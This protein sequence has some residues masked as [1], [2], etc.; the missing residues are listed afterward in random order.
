MRVAM[1][2]AGWI[3]ADH[4]ERIA[5]TDGLELVAICDVDEERARALASGADVHRDWREM[6]E[7]AEPEV[8]F[9][10][11]PP[12]LHRD[13]TLVALERGIHVYLEKPVARGLE[14]A[15]AIVDAAASAQAICAVGYQWRGVAALDPL[16]E[17]LAG[18]E[19]GLLIGVGRGPT[20]SRPWFLDRAQGGGNLLERASHIIDLERAVGG[21]VVAV[22]AAASPVPLAQ[23]AGVERGDIEDAAALILRFEHGGIGAV[24]IAWTR[25]GMPRQYALDVLAGDASLHLELDPVFTLAGRARGADIDA[26]AGAPHPSDRTLARFV[27]AI[28]SGDRDAVFCT[29][30]QA[31]GSLAVVL[32]CEEAVTTGGIVDVPSW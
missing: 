16:R 28:A 21:E 23:S 25:D 12:M 15:R 20:Q 27:E 19:I 10:C 29:P 9:V 18:Q 32:A 26:G 3:A 24:Q 1:I 2:G 13:P 11:T 14:D 31:A 7:R 6:L 30:A 17:A 5:R 22:Q 4:V 8:L